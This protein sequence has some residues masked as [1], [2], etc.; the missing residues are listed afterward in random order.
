MEDFSANTDGAIHNVVLS[1]DGAADG[2]ELTLTL[3]PTGFL[4]AGG[5]ASASESGNA[6]TLSAHGA[7]ISLKRSDLAA[8]Q[9]A[10]SSISASADTERLAKND[11]DAA[12]AAAADHARAVADAAASDAR[13]I[14]DLDQFDPGISRLKGVLGSALTRLSAVD[15]KYKAITDGMQT[16]LDRELET[17]ASGSFQRGQFS[18]AIDGRVN[19]TETLHTQV[20]G[21]STDLSSGIQELNVGWSSLAPRC[22]ASTNLTVQQRCRMTAAD[23]AEAERQRA[24]VSNRLQSLEGVYRGE[25]AKQ[26]SISQRAES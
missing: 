16:L 3:K 18:F 23:L 26:Q 1:I 17:T 25:L 11:R 7:S 4:Q 14:S 20:E 22:A 15:D 6:L 12:T 13:L 19:A 21:L 2:S 10:I 24:T 9:Q 5:T 8:Y